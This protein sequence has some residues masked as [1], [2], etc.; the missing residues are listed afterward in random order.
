MVDH[1][2][3]EKDPDSLGVTTIVAGV[4]ILGVILYLKKKKAQVR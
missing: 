1:V 4:A 2:A 3:K